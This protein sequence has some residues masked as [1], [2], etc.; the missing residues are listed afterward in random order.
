MYKWTGDGSPPEF[1][2]A[3]ADTYVGKYILVGVRYLD[4]SGRQLENQQ[5]HGVIEAATRDGIRISLRGAR[6]GQSWNMPPVLASI[7]P[8]APGRYV[9]D[10]SGEVIESPDLLATWDMREP[11]K[12]G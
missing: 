7:R 2:Q 8:A 3:L 4:H 9:L 1:D 10:E 11:S 5:M 6:F 12:Q